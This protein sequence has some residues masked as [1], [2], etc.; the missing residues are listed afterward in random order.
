[1][2]CGIAWV[3][4]SF[5]TVSTGISII[6]CQYHCQQHIGIH[7]IQMTETMC[8]I[9]VL[10]LSC[11]WYWCPVSH[12]DNSVISGLVPF[13]MKLVL[14]FISHN[15]DSIVNGTATFFRSWW[16]E[17]GAI[18]LFGYVTPL[19][20]ASA[21]HNND[22]VING[23]I[24]FLRSRWLKWG[25]TWLFGHMMPLASS[26]A[27]FLRPTCSKWGARWLLWSCDTIGTSINVTQC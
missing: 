1:M 18:S 23:T 19:P 11:H 15:A 24:A 8:N 7:Y 10:V 5:D 21:S 20:L 13:V 3:F 26:V 25:A 27:P 4:Q 2:E 9:T 17:W 6:W 22:S 14:L 12:D 16:L